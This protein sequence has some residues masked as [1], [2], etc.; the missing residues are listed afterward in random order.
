MDAEGWTN[1]QRVLQSYTA[2]SF[3]PGAAPRPRP[4]GSSCTTNFYVH[5]ERSIKSAPTWCRPMPS[6][7]G[8]R[9]REASGTARM[10][11]TKNWATVSGSSAR[12]LTNHLQQGWVR[13]QTQCGLQYQECSA[14]HQEPLLE[15]KA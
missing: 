3:P 1:C 10:R 13:A 15:R 14:W 7:H 11:G 9:E 5:H 6:S 4:Q 12:Q 2:N 8:S